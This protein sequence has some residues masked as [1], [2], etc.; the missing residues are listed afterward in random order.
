MSRWIAAKGGLLEFRAEA[1]RRKRILMCALL[2]LFTLWSTVGYA[3]DRPSWAKDL[4]NLSAKTGWYQG[5]GMAKASGKEDT[6]WDAAAGRARA[7]IAAQIKVRINS[8][9]TH[10]VQ[11]TATGTEMSL[12]DAYASTTEQLTS[13]T[14]EGIVL[15]RWYDDDAGVIYAYGAISQ[16]E[17]ERRFQAKMQDA[18]AS[19]RVYHA[20]AHKAIGR[21][22]PFTACSQLLEAMKVVSLAEASLERTISASLEE[23][24]PSVPVFPVLQ[25]QLCG[26]LSRLK[27]E[28]VSGNHQ[29]AQRGKALTEQL[30]GRVMFRSDRGLIP[31]RDAQ[32]AAV[33]IKPAAGNIPTDFRTS[34]QGEFSIPVNEITAGEAANRIRVTLALPGL[35]ALAGRFKDLE[36]CVN[37]TFIDYSFLLKS[38]SSSTVAIRIVESNMGAPRAKSSVQEQIQRLLVGSRYTVVEDSKVLRLVSEGQLTQAITSGDYHAVT[39]LLGRIAEIAIIGQVEATQRNSPMPQMCFSA[40]RAVVRVIDCKSGV[41]LASVIL[42]NEKEGGATYENAGSR[43]LEAMAKKVGD[44]V[45]TE[46]DKALE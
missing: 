35:V 1:Q 33:F 30:R 4:P 16:A 3:Q 26:F 13:A 23:T 31:L 42:E 2:C 9:V 10:A 12:T 15:D 17:V 28:V 38:R 39:G 7:Q 24:G 32:L 6:A 18:L 8:S 21:D 40:G 45:K 41:I 36:R 25:S 29:E 43:L 34:E 46:L 44:R 22:D 5:L 19:A 11:E 20:A 37:T 14:L 27:F